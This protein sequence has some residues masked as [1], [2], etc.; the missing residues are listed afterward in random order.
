LGD[1]I[2]WLNKVVGPL[3]IANSL[4]GTTFYSSSLGPIVVTSWTEEGS[5]EEESF[6]EVNVFLNTPTP[7][8]ATHADFGRQA[9]R[10]M[11]CVVQC[12]PDENYPEVHPLSDVFLEINGDGE[13]LINLE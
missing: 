6:I 1:L 4:V 3:E 11:T 2:A 5:F 12:E 9:A 10:E 8:W 13:R 7:S